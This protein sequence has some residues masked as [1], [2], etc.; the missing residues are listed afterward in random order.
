M[1]PYPTSQFCIWLAVHQAIAMKETFSTKKLPWLSKDY[2][3]LCTIYA[4]IFKVLPAEA[5]NSLLSLN[6]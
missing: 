3:P 6:H 4:L 5:L 1:K 2:A